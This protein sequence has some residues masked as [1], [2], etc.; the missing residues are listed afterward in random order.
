[1]E[2]TLLRATCKYI[3]EYFNKHIHVRNRSFISRGE[4][5][6][7]VIGANSKGILAST[8]AQCP[9][10]DTLVQRFWPKVCWMALFGI[11]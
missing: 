1:M 9:I 2:S 7:L 11:F 4:S 10:Q 3:F 8:F 6:V 5:L